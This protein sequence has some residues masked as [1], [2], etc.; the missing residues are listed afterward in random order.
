MTDSE[1]AGALDLVALLFALACGAIGI[2]ALMG[3]WVTGDLFLLRN[4]DDHLAMAPSTAVSFCLLGA[5]IVLGWWRDGSWGAQ[6]AYGLVFMVVGIA[7]VNL[8]FNLFFT[9]GSLDGWIFGEALSDMLDEDHMAIA[10]GVGMLMACYCVLALMAPENPDPDGP[11]YFAIAG[12]ST[13]I[14]ILVAHAV[15][16]ALVNDI[17]FFRGMS[18]SAA[19]A[20]C[21]FFV[22]VLAF[23]HHRTGEIAFRDDPSRKG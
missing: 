20:F 6:L 9:P 12:F 5:A 11:T 18:V 2:H 1:G 17:A 7:L 13:S 3:G 19:L 22:A 16:P 8:C 14:C 10:T 23:P 4:A 21:C 15:E